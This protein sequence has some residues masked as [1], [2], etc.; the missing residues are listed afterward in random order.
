MKLN[1]VFQQV[2]GRFQGKDDNIRP[3]LC[4]DGTKQIS[5]HNMNRE[6]IWMK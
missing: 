4:V 3:H 1:E 2:Y 6:K 5:S